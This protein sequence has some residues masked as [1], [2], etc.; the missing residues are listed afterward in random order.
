MVKLW[1]KQTVIKRFNMNYKYIFI[2]DDNGET[3][4][5]KC[6]IMPEKCKCKPRYKIVSVKNGL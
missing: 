4:R 1:S 2:R 6:Y 3:K 5:V